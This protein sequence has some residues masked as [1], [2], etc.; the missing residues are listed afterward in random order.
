MKIILSH[1][2]EVISLLIGGLIGYYFHMLKYKNNL[3]READIK[4]YDEIA[5][6]YPTKSCF[7]SPDPNALMSARAKVEYSELSNIFLFEYKFTNGSDLYFH[8]FRLRRKLAKLR[9]LY[10]K[11]SKEITKNYDHAE[12]C[13]ENFF[14]IKNRTSKNLDERKEFDAKAKEIDN[15]GEQVIEAYKDFT[16]TAKKV[17]LI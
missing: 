14:A 10:L 6:N 13:Y 5:L 16:L 1:L 3:K 2:N 15:L 11:L 4:M 12:G 9:T 7:I 8:S 17:L